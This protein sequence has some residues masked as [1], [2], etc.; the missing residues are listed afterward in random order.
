MKQTAVEW[1]ISEIF[2]S[3]KL[4]SQYQKL[5]NQAK[6]MENDQ[7]EE[8]YE[9]GLAHMFVHIK[10]EDGKKTA[11]ANRINGFKYYERTYKNGNK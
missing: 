9:W 4:N 2:P 6:E 5:L 10:I 7:I 3:K 11:D 8:A 1:L